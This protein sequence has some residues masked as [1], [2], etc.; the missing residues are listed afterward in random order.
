[1][2]NVKRRFLI[3]KRPG[4][5]QSTLIAFPRVGRSVPDDEYNMIDDQ[6]AETPASVHMR[7]GKRTRLHTRSSKGSMMAFPRVGKRGAAPNKDVTKLLSDRARNYGP[8]QWSDDQ[9][10]LVVIFSESCRQPS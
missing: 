6:N 5:P 9:G 8:E 2:P 4:E 10:I 3:H 7:F 1:M